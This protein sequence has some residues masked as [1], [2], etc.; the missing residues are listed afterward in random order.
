MVLDIAIHGT[1]GPVRI[2]EIAERLGVSVKYLEKL[3]RILKTHR[4]ITSKRGPKGGHVLSRPAE[5]ICVGEVVRVLEGESGLT[6][7]SQNSEACPQIDGCI[8][9]RVWT[10]A[11]QS[12]FAKLDSIYFDELAE[13]SQEVGSSSVFPCEKV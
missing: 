13:Q 7:C 4:Y 11:S 5:D 12:M 2:H 6:H 8:M 10:Q 1:N 9:H 3:V